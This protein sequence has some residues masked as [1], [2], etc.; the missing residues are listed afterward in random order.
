MAWLWLC[1]AL[2]ATPDEAVDL[3]EQGQATEA[4]DVFEAAATEVSTAGVA[5]GALHYNLGTAYLAA[6]DTPRA[7]AH[8]RAARV[9]YPR[10]G[11]VS[12]NLALA[13]SALDGVP[14][15]TEDAPSW[16][17]LV[18]P[19]ELGL[20]GL[21]GLLLGTVGGARAVQRREPSLGF[22]FVWLLGLT[23]G[24]A[25]VWGHMTQHDLPVLVVV[26]QEAVVRDVAAVTGLE[27]HRL[28]PGSE[29]RVER[30][31]GAFVLVQDGRGRRGW[32]PAD[33][34]LLVGD[35]TGLLPSGTGPEPARSTPPATAGASD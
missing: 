1:V 26:D 32:V 8:L 21:L 16:T 19:V 14:E 12:H 15:P 4:V 5:S 20:L 2:A 13:R 6:G 33:A 18:T 28:P 30:R 27:K 11:D 29:V 24:G 34:G 3:L 9:A 10:T 25:A 31:L 22:F 17:G 35:T 23:V 7:V